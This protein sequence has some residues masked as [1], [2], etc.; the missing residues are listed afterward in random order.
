MVR[1]DTGMVLQVCNKY[2]FSQSNSST[3]KTNIFD[4]DLMQTY[5]INLRNV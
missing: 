1:A 5:H 3:N 4:G 2:C